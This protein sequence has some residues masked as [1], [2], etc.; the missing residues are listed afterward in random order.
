MFYV[1]LDKRNKMRLCLLVVFAAV[2]SLVSCD[3]EGFS[4]QNAAN[5]NESNYLLLDTLTVNMSTIQLDSFTTNSSGV[6]LVGKYTDPAFGKIEAYTNYHV[7]V[8]TEK[9]LASKALYD[10]I[11]IILKPNGYYYGDSTLPQ[12]FQVY[13]LADK[14]SIPK[15]QYSLFNTTTT[16]TESTPVAV[17][18]Q[19]IRP[20]EKK[21]VRIILPNT[22][23]NELFEM[24][25]NNKQEVSTNEH[26]LNYFKGLSIRGGINNSMLLSYL[27][28]DSG[29]VMRLHYHEN[30][31]ELE[32]KHF[33][34]PLTGS[35]LQYNHISYD[36]SGTPLT[37]FTRENKVISSTA[38]DNVA[39]LQSFT[40]LVTRLDIPALRDLPKMGK[41][42]KIMAAELQLRPVAGTYDLLSL[43]ES[44]TLCGADR[45]N[46]VTDSLVNTLDGSIQH[47]S[48][49]IDKLY[50]ENT[51][52]TYDVTSYCT[53]Q[54]TAT[55]LTSKGLL[56]YP[57][58]HNV[59]AN[60]AVLGDTKN[61]L[62]RVSLKVY[63]LL[64]K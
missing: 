27:A 29:M 9:T 18:Q 1:M 25:K 43:P 40:G 37:A 57:N 3:K 50:H 26:F 8:P 11:E 35:G 15:E 38:L 33:D 24:I 39:Y 22:I 59:M 49:T 36:R 47:G 60:R 41:F 10:S 4:Y 46:N 5:P 31:Q 13:K 56:L 61:K 7:G 14:I 21:A 45:L 30:N 42:G 28:T 55:D 19:L 52:Y 51:K 34:F 6:A 58:G 12:T 32:R 44:I 23:G 48:L 54:T 2:V 64:Y 63:Y 62:N 53:F 17:S 20:S 16:A